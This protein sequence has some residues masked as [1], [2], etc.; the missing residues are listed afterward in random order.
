MRPLFSGLKN[1]RGFTLIEMTIVL[2]IV[3]IISSVSISFLGHFRLTTDIKETRKKQQILMAILAHYKKKYGHLPCPGTPYL[4]GKSRISCPGITLGIIPYIDLGL[5]RKDAMD[6]YSHYFTYG[7]ANPEITKPRG[8]RHLPQI[9]V[10]PHFEILTYAQIDHPPEERFAD[11][12]ILSHG[13]NGHGA[14]LENGGRLQSKGPVGRHEYV[15]AD[16][17]PRLIDFPISHTGPHYH[18]DLLVA[19]SL[20]NMEPKYGRD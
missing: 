16:D 2:M 4:K 8:P 17:S 14:Y 13:K 11:V 19:E 1:K 3:G 20:E 9:S 18:D 7:L 12:V 10:A 15:N 6:A 5:S